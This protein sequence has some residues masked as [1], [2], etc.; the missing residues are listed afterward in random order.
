MVDCQRNPM[1]A[2]KQW[3]LNQWKLFCD[4]RAEYTTNYNYLGG[5]GI[6]LPPLPPPLH[7][8]R[9]RVVQ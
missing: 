3:W 7:I 9:R 5:S 2:V 8:R 1:V 4:A 6:P